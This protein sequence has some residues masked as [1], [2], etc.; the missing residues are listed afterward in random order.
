MQLSHWHVWNIVWG[1][2][3]PSAGSG[4][5]TRPALP[6]I[7]NLAALFVAPLSAQAAAFGAYR[8]R[9]QRSTYRVT[10]LPSL[11]SIQTAHHSGG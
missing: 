8:A 6:L 3:H 1:G 4:E 5:S 10:E 2:A 9:A 11:A 7:F